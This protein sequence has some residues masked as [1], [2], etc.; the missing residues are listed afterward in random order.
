MGIPQKMKYDGWSDSVFR[1]GT[2]G[3]LYM[4]LGRNFMKRRQHDFWTKKLNI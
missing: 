3:I 1:I 2:D 4:K